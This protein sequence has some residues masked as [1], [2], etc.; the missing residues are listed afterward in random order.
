V[1]NRLSRLL[2]DGGLT[3]GTHAVFDVRD[4]DLVVT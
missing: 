2:L 4:G 3:E 1:D